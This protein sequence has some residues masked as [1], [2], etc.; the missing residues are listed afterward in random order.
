M[1]YDFLTIMK[2]YD[3]IPLFLLNNQL[4]VFINISYYITLNEY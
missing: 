1:E 3:F 4:I 2:K